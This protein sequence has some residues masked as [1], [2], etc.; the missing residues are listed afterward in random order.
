MFLARR[1]ETRENGH[2]AS[3]NYQ[4]PFRQPD[5]SVNPRTVAVNKPWLAGSAIRNVAIGEAQARHFA[6]A[7]PPAASVRCESTILQEPD[8]GPLA[9]I[10]LVA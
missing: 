2:V 10:P 6:P 7:F 1:R 8:Q 5:A 3:I 4:A 9:A